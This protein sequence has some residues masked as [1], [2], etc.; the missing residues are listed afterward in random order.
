META[1][2]TEISHDLR[3]QNLVS[4]AEKNEILDSSSEVFPD[5]ASSNCGIFVLSCLPWRRR[6]SGL[7]STRQEVRQH[8]RAVRTDAAALASKAFDTESSTYACS[9]RV[10]ECQACSCGCDKAELVHRIE[11]LERSIQSLFADQAAL[12]QYRRKIDSSANEAEQIIL[13]TVAQIPGLSNRVEA[14][15]EAQRRLI[16]QRT[17]AIEML[18]IE[19]PSL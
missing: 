9:S 15:E 2:C 13:P 4:S 10:V 11:V 3:S 5:E 6:H 7:G 17:T 16:A 1:N 18:G 8:S 14:L 19:F 12:C